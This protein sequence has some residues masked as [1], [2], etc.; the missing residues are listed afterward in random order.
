M[1]TK[2][3]IERLKDK[4]FVY[5]PYLGLQSLFANIEYQEPFEVELV[6]EVGNNLCTSFEK[7][8]IKFKINKPVAFYNELIPVSFEKDRSLPK[9]KEM[10]S[11][12]GDYEIKITNRDEL[13]GKLYQDADKRV[14]QFI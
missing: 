12:V 8:F 11:F 7:D 13:K 3:L 10:I 1:Q 14:Y 5:N 2:E 4:K 9:T 6:D